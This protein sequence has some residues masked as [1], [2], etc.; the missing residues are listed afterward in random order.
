M[1]KKEQGAQDRANA[2]FKKTEAKARHSEGIATENAA[3][4]RQVDANT[5]RLKGLRLEKE[6]A[7]REAT[8][9]K[10]GGD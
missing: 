5:A 7:D 2:A 8:R 9:T 4:A 10:T 1:S 6:R 3:K